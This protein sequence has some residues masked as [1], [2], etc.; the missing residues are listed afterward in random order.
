MISKLVS[1]ST[2]FVSIVSK[3]P[4]TFLNAP[5]GFPAHACSRSTGKQV[6][7]SDGQGM[8]ESGELSRC[9]SRKDQVSINRLG[10]E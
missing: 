9:Q 3:R 5:E 2:V 10:D 4:N 1:T 8:G 7:K 6:R